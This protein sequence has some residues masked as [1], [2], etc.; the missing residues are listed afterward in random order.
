MCTPLEHE[1]K[2]RGGCKISK[3]TVRPAAVCNRAD[4]QRRKMSKLPI[5]SFGDLPD[6]IILRIFTHLE[7]YDNASASQV[8][9]RWKSL[10]E[11]QSIWQKINLSGRQVPAKF[12]R[13]ALRHGCQY[14]RLCG[15][16][17]MNVPRPNL[18]SVSNQLKYL[19]ISCDSTDKHHDFLMETCWVH[20]NCWKNCQSTVMENIFNQISYKI[21]KL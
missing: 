7:F 12:I 1:V 5:A 13:K 2:F 4:H 16:K 11:D 20:L 6:E 15:T 21:R 17:I 19:S 8:C 14:L 9:L 18:F 3:Q 10:S